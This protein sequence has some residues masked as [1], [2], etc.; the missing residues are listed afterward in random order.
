MKYSINTKQ[1]FV[2]DS[3]KTM[4]IWPLI[5]YKDKAGK[6]YEYAYDILNDP[7]TP[8]LVPVNE[9]AHKAVTLPFCDGA[10]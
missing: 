1:Y 7:Y 6:T 8:D 9:Q 10:K 5:S 3:I 2:H 4:H